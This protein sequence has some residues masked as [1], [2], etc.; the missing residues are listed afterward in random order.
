[1]DDV[2]VTKRK[3]IMITEQAG[4]GIVQYQANNLSSYSVKLHRTSHTTL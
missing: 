4:F 3:V 2:N 1:M